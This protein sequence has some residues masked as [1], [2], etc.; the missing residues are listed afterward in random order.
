M[1]EQ[2]SATVMISAA[3]ADIMAVIADF[4][5]Y[6]SW[7]RGMKSVE[8]ISTA[9]DGRAEQVRFSLDVAP[10]R[11]EYVLAY[12]WESPTKVSWSLVEAKLL[13]ALDGVYEIREAGAGI[14][15]VDY[16][17]RLDLVVPVIGMLKRKGERMII[18]AA[19]SGLKTRVESGA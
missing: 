11:D 15:E 2:T 10:I 12:D 8:V 5:A 19:L 14:C 7:A 9:A 18:D 4:E 6:P 17:L 13:R 1:P 16:S 3:P